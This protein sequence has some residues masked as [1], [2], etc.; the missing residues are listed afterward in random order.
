MNEIKARKIAKKRVFHGIVN[1]GSQASLLAQGLRDMNI[2]AK[3]Y[4][5]GDHYQRNTD[6][7][8]QSKLWNQTQIQ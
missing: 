6:F 3:T 5:I 1:Y 4:T 8:Q 2:N 7:V